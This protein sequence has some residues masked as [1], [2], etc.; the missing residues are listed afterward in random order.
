MEFRTILAAISGG[1]ASSGAAELGCRLAERFRSHVEGLHVRLDPRELAAI[2]PDGFGAPLTGSIIEAVTRDADAA[3]AAA[4]RIFEAAR[5]RQGL[6]VQEDPPLPGGNPELLQQASACWREE[7]G[8]SS[9]VIAARGRLF[10]LI[11]LGRSGRVVGDPF[12][13]A[14]ERALLATGRPILIAPAAAPAALGETVALAW[15]DSTESAK[16]LAASLPFLARARAVYLL[17]VGRT[18]AGDVAQH[19]AW[20]GVHARAEAVSQVAG[21]DP[22]ELLLSAAR[23]RGADMLVMG[24]YG[25]PPWREMLFGGATRHVI[26]NSLLPLLLT[27]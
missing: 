10:D 17:T 24:G 6:A 23:Q 14:V 2:A 20:Y 22:G 8:S 1:V 7:T 11:V 9:E 16:A 15:N 18:P 4:K 19:L 12:G 26:G 27:H 13:D 21:V 3:A 25:R 5:S